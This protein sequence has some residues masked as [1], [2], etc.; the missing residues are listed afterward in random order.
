MTVYQRERM[1]TA[2]Y[3]ATLALIRDRF[4]LALSGMTGRSKTT[5]TCEAYDTQTNHWFSIQDLPVAL[6]NTSA[7]VMNNRFVYVMP[8]ANQEC[9]KQGGSSLTIHMLDSGNSNSLVGDK[10]SSSYGKPIAR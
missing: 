5:R 2:R 7:T 4:V 6:C 1:Q 10:N 8:A 9:L 3:G